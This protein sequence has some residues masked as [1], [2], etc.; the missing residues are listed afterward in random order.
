MNSRP[1]QFARR[2]AYAAC[3]AVAMCGVGLSVCHAQLTS[4]AV[5][6]ERLT[7]AAEAPF[8][9]LREI[10]RSVEDR[11]LWAVNIFRQ[12]ANSDNAIVVLLIGQQHGDE[13][14]GA[15]ALLD[16]VDD[17]AAA[18]ASLPAGLDLW[19]VPR[20]NPD[21]AHTEQRRNAN[22][23]DLNRD[24]VVLGQ[25]E[26][27]ALHRL[28]QT[29][30][31]HVAV[32]CHEFRRD[33]GDYLKQGW[34]EWPLIMMD[35]ANLPIMPDALYEFGVE[36]C[37]E[38]EEDMHSAGFNYARYFVGSCP[39]PQATGELRYS[40]L[41]PDDCRNALSAYGTLSFIIES[42]IHRAAEDPHADLPRRVAAS[43]LLLSR[44]VRDTELLARAKHTAE[45]AR[46]S[47]APALIPTN[48][49]WANL[50][51]RLTDLP[52]IERVTGRTLIV[53]TPTMMH[54]RVVKSAVP[55]PRGY[56]VHADAA[57]VFAELLDAHAVPYRRTVASDAFPVEA[58]DLERLEDAFDEVYSR[59]GGRQITRPRPVAVTVYPAGSLVIDAAQL[60][61]VDSRRAALVLEPR[62]LYGLYQWPTFRSLIPPD[63]TLPV[64]RL[65]AVDAVKTP[66]ALESRRD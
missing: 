11:P 15:E 16:I 54:D 23:V 1:R 41:D 27:R 56:V 65:L 63:G 24:H 45:A 38:A 53:S 43:R 44:F 55:T 51:P 37:A 5:L 21:G 14:A 64:A 19:V 12:A 59:Y 58:V 36:V 3:A 35:T 22:D 48:V 39:D 13:P 29:I 57:P 9:T 60:T 66:P 46:R 20:V 7:E 26:T 2:F 52:V 47:P 28:A 30:Q 6:V 31:P 10:G 8:V 25:P 32:D 62:Q 4:N 50:K 42:G 17:F 18:P 33:T 34:T 61:P 49:L 40:T